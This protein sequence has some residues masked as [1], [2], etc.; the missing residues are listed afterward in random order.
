MDQHETVALF[1]TDMAR[2]LAAVDRVPPAQRGSPLAYG[3]TARASH[4]GTL[5][6]PGS[7]PWV[8]RGAV[9]ELRNSTGPT[10]VM[11]SGHLASHQPDGPEVG[12]QERLQS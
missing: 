8:R 10:S 5:L 1:R 2:L 6:L 7:S 3:A 9:T 12:P 11:K 4:P